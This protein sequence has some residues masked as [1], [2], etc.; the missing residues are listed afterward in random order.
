VLQGE[1]AVGPGECVRKVPE[2]DV[3]GVLDHVVQAAGARA[4]R[5]AVAFIVS[6]L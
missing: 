6:I 2:Q 4:D 3:F 1:G 5:V